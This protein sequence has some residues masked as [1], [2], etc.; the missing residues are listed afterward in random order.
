MRIGRGTGGLLCYGKG[1]GGSAS[2]NPNS[3]ILARIVRGDRHRKSA[4]SSTD[5]RPLM[6]QMRSRV[7]LSLQG[8][9]EYKG[10]FFVLLMHTKPFRKRAVPSR[11][12]NTQAAAG[13]EW[14][15]TPGPT[16][17]AAHRRRSAAPGKSGYARSRARSRMM[18]E[19]LRH[20][21]TYP[22]RSI[23]HATGSTT[24]L[25]VV[26]QGRCRA[27]RSTAV[28]QREKHD[29]A[30]AVIKAGAEIAPC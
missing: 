3:F 28:A 30:A 18:V 10:R 24:R 6:H 19:W 17:S 5:W 29:I 15:P 7:S 26:E 25:P 8:S 16:K 23:S 2:S 22:T 11:F 20:V 9:V 1:L 21:A 12:K 13:I 4:T 14:Q 27:A